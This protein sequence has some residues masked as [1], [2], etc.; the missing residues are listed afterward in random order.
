MSSTDAP[1]LLDGEELGC[2]SY[3][4][5]V[6]DGK[7]KTYNRTPDE[8]QRFTVTDRGADSYFK[9]SARIITCIHGYME[10]VDGVPNQ[11][12]TL[13]VVEYR[14]HPKAG[15]AFNDVYTSFTFKDK[16]DTTEA[17][18]ANPQ[19]VAYAPFRR[20]R[21]WDPTV[22]DEKRMRDLG[23]TGGSGGNLPFTAEAHA[24]FGKEESHLQQYF[25]KGAANIHNNNSTGLDDTVWWSLEQNKNQKLG[26]LPVFR[27]ALLLERDSLTDFIG[28]FRMDI[29]G[30]FSYHLGQVGFNIVR[31]FRRLPIDDPVNFSPTEKSLQGKLVGLNS[32]ALGDLIQD[33]GDGDTIILP[34]I[35]HL[36]SFLPAG[37]E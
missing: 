7:F 13:L 32:N 35:Y 15:H 1:K 3:D 22:A 2:T 28:E 5:P 23:M 4:G 27:V 16:K 6:S 34:D 33:I 21:K 29:H 24:N 14:L 17:D 10:E 20:P 19:V 12:A 18:R 30:S 36:G 26:V 11:P 25:A 37:V 31:F 8:V 9:S